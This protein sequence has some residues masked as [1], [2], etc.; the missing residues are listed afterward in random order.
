MNK[1]TP[2]SHL[3]AYRAL[4]FACVVSIVVQTI[5]IFIDGA[6]LGMFMAWLNGAHVFI[7]LII[8][9][10]LYSSREN[11]PSI[12]SLEVGFLILFAPFLATTWIGETTGLELG[13]IRQPFVPF[14]FLCICIAVLSPGRVVVAAAEIFVSLA[15]AVTFWFV[16]KGQYPLKGITGEPWATLTFGLIALMML[17]ARAYR[18]G[19]IQKLEKTRAEAEAFERAARLFL[20]VRDRANSP[21]Q[22][23]NLCASLIVARNPEETETVERLQRSLIKLKELTDILAETEVWRETYKAG[24]D[25]STEIDKTFSKLV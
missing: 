4:I 8:G 20:A 15:V 18:K 3:E 9:Y 1:H 11:L 23:I 7:S 21:L 24:G 2:E 16:L 17:S 19:I 6:T 25:I 12:K 14:Q 13:Q 5:F 22:V 10:W